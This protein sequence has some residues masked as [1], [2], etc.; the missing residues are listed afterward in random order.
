MTKSMRK[1]VFGPVPSKRLGLSLG[2]DVTP[3]KTCTLNCR[4]CQLKETIFLETGR[5]SFFKPE[6][7][8]A[9][10]KAVLEHG[11]KPDWITFSGTGEPTLYSGLGHLIDQIKAFTAIPICVITNGTLLY[12]K[13]V[14]TDLKHAD[15]VLP[16]LCSLNVDTFRK[17]HRPADGLDVAKIPE[18]LRE[19]AQE[20][21]GILEVEVFVCPGLNDSPEEIAAIAKFLGELPFLAGVYLNTAVRYPVDA[22]FRKATPEEMNLFRSALALSVPVSTVYDEV[23]AHPPEGK[24]YRRPAMEEVLALLARHPS[25]DEQIR[26][27]LGGSLEGI[28]KLLNH[29]FKQGKIKKSPDQTWGETK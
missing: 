3:A 19:F 27:A 12:H 23:A 22:D 20:Y 2:I 16:T 14:R 28:Q 13:Q 25:T 8:V 1:F 15:K 7:I 29:L 11:Q 17:I 6:E 21:S 5:K 18:G 4:Y 10:L 24:D 26:K 9:E